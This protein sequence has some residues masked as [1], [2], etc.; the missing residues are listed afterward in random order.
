MA[1]K[2]N[3]DGKR[4]QHNVEVLVGEVMEKIEF[5]SNVEFVAKA[6]AL[7]EDPEGYPYGY[8]NVINLCEYRTEDGRRCIA[9]RMF[10]GHV[11]EDSS[12][13][14]GLSSASIMAEETDLIKKF[15]FLDFHIVNKIQVQH[16][17]A[18][19]GEK[20]SWTWENIEAAAVTADQAHKDKG[21]EKS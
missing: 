18:A 21:Q 7:L 8:N 9:G 17:M 15:P 5:S 12:F 11:P 13:W 10:F 14:S 20:Q 16:D 6:K 1:L 19:K 2:R 4:S 3:N